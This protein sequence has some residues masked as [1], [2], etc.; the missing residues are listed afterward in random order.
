LITSTHTAHDVH[1]HVGVTLGTFIAPLRVFGQRPSCLLYALILFAYNFVQSYTCNTL[2][3][4]TSLKFGFNGKENGFIITIAHSVATIYIFLTLYV[5]PQLSKSVSGPLGF[6]SRCR[7]KRKIKHGIPAIISLS[8]QAASLLV[9]G[10]ATR[11]WQT[12][13]ATALLAL[14]LPTPSFIK[15]YVV[16]V[17]EESH[18][19]KALASLATME[20]VGDVVGPVIFGGW[21]S[22]RPLN[23]DTFFGAAGIISVSL[24]LFVVRLIML[25]L[26]SEL[27][28]QEVTSVREG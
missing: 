21:Q 11:T 14:G 10:L 4:H 15:A 20:V 7:N 25:R 13:I 24:I 5:I 3:V 1:A 8:L 2:L 26:E 27:D 9:V 17:F 22:H 23:G 16:G 6:R 19:S 28:V 18:K 12:Y